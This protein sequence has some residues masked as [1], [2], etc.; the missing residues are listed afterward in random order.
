MEFDFR[1][2]VTTFCWAAA[3]V[4]GGWQETFLFVAAARG[5]PFDG[6]CR[7]FQVFTF[8]NLAGRFTYLAEEEK[9]NPRHVTIG[10][11]GR[12]PLGE[13]LERG[14]LVKEGGC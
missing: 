1:S 3:V 4:G 10:S 11:R 7:M 2:N 9:K 8:P 6:A 5:M 14:Y 12:L 13:A